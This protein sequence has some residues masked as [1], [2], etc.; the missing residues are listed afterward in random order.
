[1]SLEQQLRTTLGVKVEIKQSSRGKGR[2]TIQF[3]SH[4]EFDRIVAS[5]H[6]NQNA[7]QSLGSAFDQSRPIA[8]QN[9]LEQAYVQVG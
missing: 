5:L 7:P 6:P 1:V 9:A 8:E 4:E 2:I 3:K